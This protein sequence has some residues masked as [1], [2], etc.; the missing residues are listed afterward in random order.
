[1]PQLLQRILKTLLRCDA[2]GPAQGTRTLSAESITRQIESVPDNPWRHGQVEVGRLTRGVEC[3]PTLIPGSEGLDFMAHHSGLFAHADQ[4]K[5]R[6]REERSHP[7][8]QPV[9]AEI[10]QCIRT[11]LQRMVMA[12]SEQSRE[13][14]VG[15][16][17]DV[18]IVCTVLPARLIT[19]GHLQ[20]INRQIQ[21]SRVEC[22][23][24]TT[25][26][27]WPRPASP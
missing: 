15:G 12:T 2:S 3:E 10:Q 4:M 6:H 23:P 17:N 22:W 20:H 27:R 1:M 24:A 11:D 8:R 18:G 21:R 5:H 25:V 16:D 19:A 26:K 7:K 14:P 13:H 9:V